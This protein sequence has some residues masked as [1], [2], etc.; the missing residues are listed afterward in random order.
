MIE[1]T[2]V[3]EVSAGGRIFSPQQIAEVEAA[4][5]LLHADN[6]VAR[7]YTELTTTEAN[8]H[9]KGLVFG[10]AMIAFRE[11]YKR[12]GKGWLARLPALGISQAK[13]FYWIYEIEKKPNDR[14]RRYWADLESAAP[15]NPGNDREFCVTQSS[16]PASAIDSNPPADPAKP[17][18]R[19]RKGSGT[20]GD[21]TVEVK[22]YLSAKQKEKF[23]AA[24]KKLVG[25]GGST[26]LHE[27][28]YHVVI[29]KAAEFDAG[30]T[31][32]EGTLLDVLENTARRGRLTFLPDT[33]DTLPN[34]GLSQPEDAE[35]RQ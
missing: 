30:K 27:A 12:K 18:K 11:A 22:I 10:Q 24:A 25:L 34:L 20:A 4:D 1:I 31:E 16:I 28:I 6:A 3:K 35:V 21:D 33:E 19:S 15:P 32:K 14:H 9:E 7:A 26:N 8:L 2:E 29:Q 17:R 13:A 5:T 23:Q